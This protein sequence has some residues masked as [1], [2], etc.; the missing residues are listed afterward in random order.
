MDQKETYYKALKENNDQFDEIELGSKLGLNENETEVIIAMLLSEYRID[1][2]E[3]KICAY[4]ISKKS[5]RKS[6]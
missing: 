4:T 6:S 3:N 1:Y 2:V 5:I